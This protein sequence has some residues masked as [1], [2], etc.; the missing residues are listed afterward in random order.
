MKSNVVFV[1]LLTLGLAFANP[2][3]F[4]YDFSGFT[5]LTQMLATQCSDIEGQVSISNF[6]YIGLLM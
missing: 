1:V 3:N 5:K 2:P 6:F 4:N